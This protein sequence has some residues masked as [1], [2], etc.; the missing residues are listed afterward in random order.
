MN[1]DEVWITL[2]FTGPSAGQQVQDT[3]AILS[4]TIG[5]FC[6]NGASNQHGHDDPGL[7]PSG[8]QLPLPGSASK[9]QSLQQILP[10]IVVLSKSSEGLCSTL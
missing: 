8:Q 10:V 4:R 7:L 5:S 1:P 9:G 6:M 3:S 2:T